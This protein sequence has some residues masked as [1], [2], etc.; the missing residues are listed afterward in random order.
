MNVDPA[1]RPLESPTE[2]LLGDGRSIASGTDH[3]SNSDNRG[4]STPPARRNELTS[5]K[6]LTQGTRSL[7]QSGARRVLTK[8]AGLSRSG[9]SWSAS[10]TN[11][12]TKEEGEGSQSPG[13]TSLL[14]QKIDSIVQEFTTVTRKAGARLRSDPKLH[15]VKTALGERFSGAVNT[16]KEL[17]TNPEVPSSVTKGDGSP[18][19]GISPNDEGDGTTSPSNESTGAGGHRDDSRPSNNRHD[20]GQG[21]KHDGDHDKGEDDVT[22]TTMETVV[23]EMVMAEVVTTEGVSRTLVLVT[24]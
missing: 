15:G 24:Q 16:W 5:L 20:R 23:M 13:S 4:A 18:L 14:S 21:E 17:T 10:R 22:T 7:L 2:S 6:R 1:G 12:E 8:D 3:Y 11:E 19:S 9:S